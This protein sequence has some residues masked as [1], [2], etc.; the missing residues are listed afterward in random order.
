MDQWENLSISNFTS[1]FAEK[2]PKIFKKKPSIDPLVKKHF[3]FCRHPPHP[4]DHRGSQRPSRAANPGLDS[5]CWPLP[6]ELGPRI[7]GL[8]KKHEE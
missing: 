5:L 6:V 8:E 4:S 2:M 7:T 3:F 1:K